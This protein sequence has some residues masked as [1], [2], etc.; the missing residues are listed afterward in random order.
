MNS[1]RAYYVV[2]EYFTTGKL[3][4]VEEVSKREKFIFRKLKFLKFCNYP[5]EKIIGGK[6]VNKNT[7]YLLKVLNSYKDFKY[8]SYV[9]KKYDY[10]KGG[11]KFSLYTFLRVDA[12][13]IDIFMAF[14]FSVRLYDYLSNGGYDKNNIEDMIIEAIKTNLEWIKKID[15]KEM[16][17]R[18]K[19]NNWDIA[20]FSLLEE[21]FQ[22][23][24]FFR[25]ENKSDNSDN[26]DNDN[27]KYES[28]DNIRVDTAKNI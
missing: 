11:Y 8:M 19:E 10:I 18:L 23:Y 9:E 5:L 3:L 14:L 16:I 6:S 12:E 24:Q 7:E 26:S 21:K 25:E 1:Q 15:K 22:R 4:D 13:R 27:E 20:S 17:R 28:N 2:K